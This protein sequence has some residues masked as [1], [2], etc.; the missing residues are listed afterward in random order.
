MKAALERQRLLGAVALAAALPLPFTGA[1]GVPFMVPF[2]VVAVLATLSGRLLPPLPAWGEN[3]LAPFVL[4]GVLVGGGLEY[5]ILRPVANLALLVAAVRLPGCG[6]AG[7]AWGT[8]GVLSVIAV[9]GVASS[10]HPSL[11]LYLVAVLGLALVVAAR[12]VI[13]S[14]AEQGVTGTPRPS[15]PSPRAAA[16]TAAFTL[17]LAAPLFVALPRLRSPFATSPLGGRAVSGFREAVALH[18]LGEI[19]VSRAVV[20]RVRFEQPAEVRPE[21]LR[22]VGSTVRHYRGGVWAQGRR[23]ESLV[24]PSGDGWSVLGEAEQPVALRQAKVS[25]V[26]ESE[27]LFVP[28]GAVAIKLAGVELR[29]GPLG[30]LRIPRSTVPP[31]VY[32]VKFRPDDVRQEPPDERDV[33]VPASLSWLAA[34]GRKVTEGSGSTLAAAIS[35]ESYLRSNFTYAAASN[36]PLR[37]DPVDWFLNASGEGHCEFFASSMVLL[38]RSL[39]IPAR[40]QA[41]YLGGESDGE[42]GYVVRDSHAHAWVVAWVGEDA[43]G[44]AGRGSPGLRWRVF[45]PTPPEG[46]PEVSGAVGGL[47]WHFTWQ[48]LESA[49]DRWVLTYSLADQI[50]VARGIAHLVGTSGGVIGPALAVLLGVAVVAGIL[51]RRVR[52][53]GAA[54]QLDAGPAAHALGRVIAEARALGLCGDEATTPRE[55]LRRTAT[56]VPEAVGELEW[57]VNRHEQERYGGRGGLSRVAAARS[58][59]RIVRELQVRRPVSAPGGRRRRRA[60]V[61]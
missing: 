38:L 45:D 14:M 20:M 22:F 40:L 32:E 37:R 36:A 28:N 21:W 41:G 51:T 1:A 56:L 60:P 30:T 57:L 47:G 24:R 6:M 16:L 54:R 59:R 31:V 52:P 3:L 13:V 61:P 35:V 44:R 27:S 18:R 17:V 2:A 9:A 33:E 12:L 29:R 11:A 4:A 55:F 5:G 50:G 43:G 58:A 10:T 49:W 15:L 46:Q 42:G 23:G 39:G 8:G 34:L 25:L 26:H 53:R 48:R 19:K 7:R